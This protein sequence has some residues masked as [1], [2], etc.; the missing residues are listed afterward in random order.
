[1]INME[2][3]CQWMLISVIIVAISF[4]L[5]LFFLPKTHQGYYLFTKISSDYPTYHIW[6]N[7]RNCPDDIAFTTRDKDEIVKVFKILKEGG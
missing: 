1:M 4:A 2:R 6:N 7:W 3:V 5:T